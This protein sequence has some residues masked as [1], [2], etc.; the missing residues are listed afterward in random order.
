MSKFQIVR[1]S[2]KHLPLI[3]ELDKICLPRCSWYPT[4]YVW[5]LWLGEKLVGY[6]CFIE[7]WQEKNCGYLSRSGILPKFRGTGLHKRL[8]RVRLSA[9]RKVGCT[10]VVTDT[11][12]NPASVNNLIAC[13]FQMYQP[14]KPWGFVDSWYWRKTL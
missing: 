3:R 10:V 2:S 1:A 12:Q 8:I 11:R 4:D 6:T 5:G 13:G 14:K 7:S 9:A